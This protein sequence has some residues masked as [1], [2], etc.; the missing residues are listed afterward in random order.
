MKITLLTFLFLFHSLYTFSQKKGFAPDKYEVYKKMLEKQPYH[1]LLTGTSEEQP[2]L[3]DWQKR[4]EFERLKTFNPTT[5]EIPAGA[6]DKARQSV[7]K[8]LQK[9]KS[10]RKAAG[11]P[12]VKWKEL[13][14]ANVGGRTRGIMYDPND[15]TRNKVWSGGVSGG[16][17]Y[18]NNIRDANSGWNK[19]DDFWENMSVSCL[20]FDPSN[21][22][23]FYVGTGEIAGGVVQEVGFMWK[24]EDAGKTWNK[25]PNKPPGTFYMYRIV[26]NKNGEV[27]VATGAGVQK[28][29]D[30]G[31]TWKTVLNASAGGTTDIEMASDQIMYVANNSGKIYRSNDASGNQWTEIT[32]PIN[33]VGSRTELGL[34]L[35][36]QGDKQVIYAYNNL[37]WF[38]KSTNAGKTWENVTTPVDSYGTPF[39]GDQGFYDLVITVHPTNPNI[40]YAEG[41]K[42]G[43]STDGGKTWFVYEYYFIHPDHHNVV[44]NDK[45]NDEAIFSCD[46]G[47]YYSADAGQNLGNRPKI[48]ER[49]KNYNTTQ[50]YSVA[51]R[52]IQ[53][54]ETVIGGAQDNG[55]WKVSS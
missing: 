41:N 54:D 18:N 10:E 25:L 51:I 3:A 37:N 33:T 4:F 30:G 28:S 42:V 19:I 52:N 44:F 6:M 11:I 9:A 43:K 53:N 16:L 13:G 1:K 34:A 7:Q 23:I 17:W 32:P 8:S 40:V 50:F 22:K 49:N 26:V 38:Q 31:L 36:T 12:N 48:E 20:A 47:V 5:G 46:G 27:F 35:S 15:A 14:P 24:S 39:V 29:V 45:N 21:P 55:S 2:K